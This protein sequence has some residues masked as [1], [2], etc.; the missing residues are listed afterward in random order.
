M[1]ASMEVFINAI[2][3][4]E[5]HVHIE[6]TF[7]PE[8]M[9][10]IAERNGKSLDGTVESHKEKRRNF[11]D[12]QD[13][14]DVYYEACDVLQKEEDFY[15]LMYAYLQRASADSVYYVEIFFDPQTHTDR[16]ISF[17]TVINGLHR[18]IVEGQKLLNIKAR[19]IM[20]FLR[21]LSEDDAMATLEQAKPHIAKILG[22]GLDSG[23]KGNPPSK[24]RNVFQKA[25]ELGLKLVAHAGEEMGPEY[26]R[27]ALD[28]LQVERID[29]GVQCRSD[30]D[31]VARLKRDKIPL[32]VCPLSNWKLKV[33]Q[34]FMGD[35]SRVRELLHDGLM[36]TINSDDPAYFGG[37]IADNFTR[38]VQDTGLTRE[39]MYQICQNAFQASFLPPQDKE[40]YLEELKHFGVEM[41]ICPA[42]KSLVV[43]GA[44]APQ[45][46]SAEYTFAYDI[47]KVFG[48]AGYKIINGGYCG[49]MQAVSEGAHAAGGKVLGVISTRV[50]TTLRQN[51]SFG[52]EYLSE[53]ANVLS[54]SD[55]TGTM[56]QC[57]MHVLI[58]PGSIGTMAEFMHALYYATTVGLRRA[59]TP[60][61][62]LTR[63]PWERVVKEVATL[64]KMSPQYQ[65]NGLDRLCFFDK[66]EEALELV[67]KDRRERFNRDN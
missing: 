25:R 34:R 13:F 23:E 53:V 56:L 48:S 29:H 10:K 52:N 50:F 28:V 6:G 4:A 12:L 21:H 47:G 35:Q 18:A 60:R 61:M 63:E 54:P 5:L 44:H 33:N 46:G 7:E 11:E 9:F 8:L 27:E 2:P 41:G 31:L 22:V 14:L 20:C 19:L 26:I 37:Y 59:H 36:V 3:K 38:T 45:P 58:L 51:Q 39:E 62:F 32:T 15:D 67:E 17:D 24:F 42:P 57:A 64:L 65:S 43:F 66:P 40:L 49:T 55:R 30:S 1:A 16:G